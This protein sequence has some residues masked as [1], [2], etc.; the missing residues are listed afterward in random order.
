MLYT[1]NKFGDVCPSFL[2]K[3]IKKSLLNATCKAE[4]VELTKENFIFCAQ[5]RKE[6]DKG[7]K[8]TRNTIIKKLG[9]NQTIIGKNISI[10]YHNWLIPLR[11]NIEKFNAELAR[12]ESTELGKNYRKSEALTSLSLRW[13]RG[14]DSN[15]DSMLQRHESYH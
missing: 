5:A 11:N 10:S 13:L 8:E 6:F 14:L 3:Y 12:L 7:D 2:T 9:S 15:Q 1:A 4:L